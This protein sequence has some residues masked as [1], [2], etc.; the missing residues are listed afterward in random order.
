MELPNF[1]KELDENQEASAVSP[2][3][4]EPSGAGKSKR[5]RRS[6]ASSGAIADSEEPTCGA[7]FEE[8]GAADHA[9][10][11]AGWA[12]REAY[13]EGV[14]SEEAV[15]HVRAAKASLK[16]VAAAFK[17]HG[18]STERAE[19]SVRRAL[20]RSYAC[21]EALRDQ[22][23]VVNILL[24]E[25]RIKR[26][27]P[28][29]DNRFLAIIKIANPETAPDTVSRW[30][31]ALAYA[32][33]SGCVEEDLPG[34]LRKTGIREAADRWVE[35]RRAAKPPSTK[36][37]AK[38]DPMENL[39]KNSPGIELPCDLLSPAASRGP[40]LVIADRID[41]H[42]VALAT[43]TDTRIVETAIR[44]AAKPKEST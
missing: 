39:R 2:P 42:L 7:A 3:G 24:E 9:A 23:R 43:I 8:R 44:H 25:K 20:A 17:R 29:R 34:F 27:K 1:L 22:P 10:A 4:S 6:Q 19:E 16:P 18:A 41:N 12:F 35:I 11:A 13:P 15:A 38:A 5:S 21:A 14:L 26:T 36:T 40:F 28:V 32:A 30:A 33:A 31:S 37:V